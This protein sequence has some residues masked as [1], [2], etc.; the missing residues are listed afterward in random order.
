MT[1][2]YCLWLLVEGTTVLE[3]CWFCILVKCSGVITILCTF[4]SGCCDSY[5]SLDTNYR[6]FKG[7]EQHPLI[8][9]VSVGQVSPHG[10][11]G[12]SAH[13][14][15]YKPAKYWPQS[16]IYTT[17][18]LGSPSKLVQHVDRI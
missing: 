9:S 16:Y 17:E 3:S 1:C 11:P 7:L 15:L 8:I 4:G 18:S 12:S 6:T 5:P 14:G 2:R 13:D 10:L